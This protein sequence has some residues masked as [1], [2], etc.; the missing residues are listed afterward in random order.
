M[1]K[2]R[3]S[4]SLGFLIMVLS[5]TLLRQTVQYFAIR[6]GKTQTARMLAMGDHGIAVDLKVIFCD[7][8]CLPFANPMA[9]ENQ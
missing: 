9:F 8:V 4:F 3:F 5:S 6:L 2:N 7:D 1:A